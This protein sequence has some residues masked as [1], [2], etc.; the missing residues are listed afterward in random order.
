MKGGYERH[1]VA[2]MGAGRDGDGESD[3]DAGYDAKY[4]DDDAD[5]NILMMLGMVLM[6]NML[7]KMRMPIF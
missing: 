4:V 3:D 7:M 5:A 2:V 6:P 1:L